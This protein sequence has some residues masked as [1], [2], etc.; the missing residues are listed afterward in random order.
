MVEKSFLTAGGRWVWYLLATRTVVWAVL[1][2]GWCRAGPDIRRADQAWV[3]AVVPAA[4]RCECNRVPW[5]CVAPCDGG[6]PEAPGDPSP[7]GR[8]TPGMSGTCGVPAPRAAWPRTFARGA[9]VAPPARALVAEAP[10]RVRPEPVALPAAGPDP[11]E[12]GVGEIAAGELGAGDNGVVELDTGGFGVVEL[13]AGEF[14]TGELGAG[15]GGPGDFSVGE[16][17]AD[18]A[19]VVELGPGVRAA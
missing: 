16:V 3:V 11:A 4:D 12:P 8:A 1:V 9:L 7:A 17:G 19:G 5:P 18:E 14:G 10:A 6:D 15:E 2:R 13:G